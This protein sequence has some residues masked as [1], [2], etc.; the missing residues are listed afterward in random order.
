MLEV[1]FAEQRQSVENLTKQV[2]ELQFAIET[3]KKSQEVLV[4]EKEKAIEEVKIQ[5]VPVVEENKFD[6]EEVFMSCFANFTESN[7][8]L[9]LKTMKMWFQNIVTSPL[10]KQKSRINITNP[11][12]KNYFAGN[13][14]AD[15]L[16]LEVGFVSRGNFLEFEA[17][18]TVRIQAVLEKITEAITNLPIQA[19]SNS[20]PWQL[21]R[22]L[23]EKK[24]EKEEKKAEKE[25]KKVEKEVKNEEKVEKTTEKEEIKPEKEEEN[26]ELGVISEPKLEE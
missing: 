18:S 19:F 13:S 2:A 11:Q 12:Y 10:D 5:E 15:R 1:K 22:S 14:E 21:N 3:L 7:K 23:T 6:V 24:P 4:K 26:S 16:F 20:A 25:E 9:A 17:A 8:G